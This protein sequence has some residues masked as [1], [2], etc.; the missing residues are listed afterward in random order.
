MSDYMTTDRIRFA[1]AI[2][3]RSHNAHIVHA[4]DEGALAFD[5]WKAANDAAVLREA[6]LSGDFGATA[7]S[8]LL[9]H[10]DRIE[11]GAAA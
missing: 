1:A 2:G 9:R 10:A 11:K 4:D 7:Q 6:A 5:R 8:T 3:M